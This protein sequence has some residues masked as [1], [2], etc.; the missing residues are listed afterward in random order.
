[1]RRLLLPL[2]ALL[3]AASCATTGSGGGTRLKATDYHPL[4]VGAA[5]TYAGKVGG[6]AVEKTITITGKKDGYFADDAGGLLKVDAEG[7]RDEKR[8]LLKNPLETG[9]SWTSIVSVSSTEHYEI[10]D[11]GFTINTA[12]GQ[13]NDCILVR[14][15]N[16]IDAQKSLRNEWTFAPKVGMVRIVGAM[17]DG[18]REMPQVFLELKSFKSAPEPAAAPAPAPEAKPGAK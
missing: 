4:A 16:R 10:V 1:M 2:A 7:L 11:T 15:T 14:G 8:Y 13:F 3:I 6:Q 9:K 5:W 12:A 18:A 17:V